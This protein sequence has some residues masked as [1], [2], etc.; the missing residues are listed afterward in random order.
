[1]VLSPS[2]AAS[3]ARDLH[4]PRHLVPGLLGVGRRSILGDSGPILQQRFGAPQ[5]PTE[6]P[7]TIMEQ[8]TVGGMGDGGGPD[9]AVSPQLA[10]LRP[11]QGAR[12]V[13]NL[14]EQAVQRGGLDALRPAIRGTLIRDRLTVDPIELA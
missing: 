7:Y 11:L 1:M 12:Q 8:R 5:G 10:A 4:H 9:R 14:I 2:A 3:L 6:A 13:G